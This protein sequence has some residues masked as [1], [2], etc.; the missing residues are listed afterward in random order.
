[1]AA[2][3]KR[4]IVE[5]EFTGTTS[6][7]TTCNCLSIRD[8]HCPC[9]EDPQFKNRPL[10]QNED[11]IDAVASGICHTPVKLFKTIGLA[12]NIYYQCKQ[13]RERNPD[14]V[15]EPEYIR[16]CLKRWIQSCDKSADLKT[17]LKGIHEGGFHKIY[18]DLF[19]ME[20]VNQSLLPES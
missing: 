12:E 13:D 16:T 18:T 19:N 11:V 6:N 17:L 9:L 4:Q 3:I 2:I 20:L 1:M 7:E 8:C 10:D 14:N 15:S 5:F